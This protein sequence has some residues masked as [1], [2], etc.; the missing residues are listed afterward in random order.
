M[1]HAALLEK[2]SWRRGYRGVGIKAVNTWGGQDRAAWGG[3][4][5]PHQLPYK[6][7]HPQAPTPLGRHSLTCS[8][9]C[10]SCSSSNQG[11]KNTLTF[12]SAMLME[13]EAPFFFQE[14]QVLRAP[15]AN[16]LLLLLP[17][18]VPPTGRGEGSSCVS[19]AGRPRGEHVP[20]RNDLP[21]LAWALRG[22]ARQDPR[23]AVS[24]VPS[25][26]PPGG[27]EAE[28]HL[29]ARVDPSPANSDSFAG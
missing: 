12:S 9:S 4:A 13:K 26:Q 24:H 19:A 20:P 8:L 3:D 10:Q 23:G 5:S 27:A 18:L 16:P 15:A 25:C 22:A 11:P 1:L 17:S 14:T 2:G 7:V 6:Q 21:A 28:T 29:P